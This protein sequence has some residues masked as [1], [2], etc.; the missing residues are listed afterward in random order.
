M[1]KTHWIIA[2]VAVGAV[3]ISGCQSPMSKEE[4][5][6]RTE[7]IG[8]NT[9]I[10]TDYELSRNFKD[11][12]TGPDRA[13]RLSSAA[14]GIEH[15]DTGTSQVWAELRNHTDHNYMVEARTQFY[16]ESGMPTDAKPV[17]QRISVPA[18]ARAI[19]REKSTGTQRLQYRIEVRQAR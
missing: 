11:G 12:L 1:N 9:V 17:W 10:F 15:T 6:Q 16:T 19:Y 14:H 4:L 8:Y 18:N 5:Q 3:L 2:A 13:I 7:E